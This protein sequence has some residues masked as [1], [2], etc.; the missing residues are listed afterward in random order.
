MEPAL[1][2]K[3][4]R[5]PLL[6]SSG[7][8]DNSATA[9]SGFP[10]LRLPEELLLAI[11]GKLPVRKSFSPLCELLRNGGV[12]TSMALHHPFVTWAVADLELCRIDRL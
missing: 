7:G 3:A 4:S 9:A 5:G 6:G 12:R 2:A 10:L 8:V 1:A 11:A